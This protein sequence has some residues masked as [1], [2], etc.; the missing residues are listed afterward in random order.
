MTQILTMPREEASK[1]VAVLCQGIT[2][3]IADSGELVDLSLDALLSS[4]LT[5]AEQT[6]RMHEVPAVLSK[7]AQALSNG[8]IPPQSVTKH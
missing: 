4:Y 6:G 5:I 3:L 1:R 2:Q 8:L 7:V